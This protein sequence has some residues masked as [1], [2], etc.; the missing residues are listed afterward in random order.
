M[1]VCD[2]VAAVAVGPVTAAACTHAAYMQ[3]AL[4][5]SVVPPVV[6]LPFLGSPGILCCCVVADLGGVLVRAAACFGMLQCLHN[7]L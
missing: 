6:E 3:Q 7:M 4:L 5:D 1:R 2:P